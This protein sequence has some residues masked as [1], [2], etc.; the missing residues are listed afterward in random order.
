MYYCSSQRL[1]SRE[2]KQA[3]REKYNLSNLTVRR[4][5]EDPRSSLSHPPRRHRL[6]RRLRVSNP[7]SRYS[8]RTRLR[9]GRDPRR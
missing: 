9:R 7:R 1:S 4:S 8:P 2:H 6:L 3:P 5:R